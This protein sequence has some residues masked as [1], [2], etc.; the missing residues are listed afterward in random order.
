MTVSF[1]DLE[2]RA[3]EKTVRAAGNMPGINLSE[4][5]S[6][7]DVHPRTVYRYKNHESAPCPEVRDRSGKLRGLSQ[8]LTEVFVDKDAQLA[9]LCGP[10]P[11]LRGEQHGGSDLLTRSE[12]GSLTMLY[13]SWPAFTQEL[14]R[15]ISGDSMAALP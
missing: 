11:M 5:A 6:A 3:A 4:V 7:L 15:E 1:K 13:R 2:L 12:K 10:V 9:W 8:L 14:L